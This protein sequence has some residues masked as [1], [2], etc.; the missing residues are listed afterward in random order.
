MLTPILSLLTGA[1]G[2]LL[3]IFLTPRLQHY[4]WKRQRL[5]D[6]QISA[7]HEIEQITSEFL[8]N[9]RVGTNGWFP[10][11]LEKTAEVNSLFDRPAREK[12]SNLERLLSRGGS[13]GPGMLG[14]KGEY[15]TLDFI[16]LRDEALREIYNEIGLI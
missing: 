7:A 10:D 8:H 6:L 12:L 2:S 1:I 14:P 15:T 4:F 13:S 9:C 11:E 5:G 3:T 16:G